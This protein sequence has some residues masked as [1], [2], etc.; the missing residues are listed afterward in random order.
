MELE[1]LMTS[2]KTSFIR[3]EI[4]S[5]STQELLGRQ[6]VRTTFKL[7]ERSIDAM[8]VLANQL[9]IK[10]KSL[11]DHLIDDD[12]VMKMIAEESTQYEIPEQRVAKTY[13]ISRRTLQ[14]LEKISSRYQTPRDALVELSIERILPLITEEKKK[15][16]QRKMI[17]Q[18]LYKMVDEGEEIF[19]MA[20]ESLD[21]DD[22]VYRRIYQ[23]VK[24]V[25]NCCDDVETFVE[26][27]RKIEEF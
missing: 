22:P 16:K 13:V 5:K 21:K 4:T 7:T 10:Q 6:S 9:G 2:R 3:L 17:L 1:G 19:D 12:S 27:G 14:N 23:M 11:F 25:R 8:S 15:H 26:R 20:N 24:T 18:K